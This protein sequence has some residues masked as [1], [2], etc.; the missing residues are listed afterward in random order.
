VFVLWFVV[1]LLFLVLVSFLSLALAADDI[2]QGEYCGNGDSCAEGLTCYFNSCR[3]AG[4]LNGEANGF[5]NACSGTDCCSGD[6]VCED[7]QQK[8]TAKFEGMPT[9]D[10]E[11]GGG[12]GFTPDPPDA[13]PPN[14]PNP[15][16][17]PN[18]P[19]PPDTPE[20]PNPPDTPEEPNPPNPPDTPEE[21]NPPNPPDTPEEPNPPNPPDTPDTDDIPD[22]DVDTPGTDDLPDLPVA[23]PDIGDLDSDGDTSE[24]TPIPEGARAC[25]NA[26][27]CGDGL[28]CVSN[29]C[30]STSDFPAGTVE[31]SGNTC[32]ETD[33]CRAG[34]TCNAAERRCQAAASQLPIVTCSV[35]PNPN[36]GPVVVPP[37]NSAASISPSF[38][39]LMFVSF[40]AMLVKRW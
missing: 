4:E 29:V 1:G 11:N 8:C 23:V 7:S 14:P 32:S 37:Q 15:P 9:I 30:R 35:E 22:V 16:E 13:E 21:P 17:E 3:N 19:N 12:G 2:A 39:A 26:D 24:P 25:G 38:I 36:G 31:G 33:C 20:E 34:L 6:L 28:I 27:T 10:C 18:P 40:F 5:G